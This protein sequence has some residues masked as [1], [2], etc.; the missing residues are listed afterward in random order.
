[1]SVLNEMQRVELLKKLLGDPSHPDMTW[2]TSSPLI[3]AA[4]TPYQIS[5]YVRQAKIEAFL[6]TAEA[7]LS[8]GQADG[9]PDRGIRGGSAL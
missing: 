1:V 2:I 9:R 7:E 5:E 4:L 6:A 3:K 8:D